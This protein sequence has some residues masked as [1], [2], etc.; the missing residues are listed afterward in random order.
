MWIYSKYGFISCIKEDGL[1]V[2]RARDTKIL[3]RINKNRV[4]YTEDSDYPY[5]I[6]LTTDEFKKLLMTFADDLNY[7]NFKDSTKKG[8]LYNQ[9]LTRIWWMTRVLDPRETK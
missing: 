6:F 1:I 9:L 4:L 2:V 7:D 5:R 3:N 8:S